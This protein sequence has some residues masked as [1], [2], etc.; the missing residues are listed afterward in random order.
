[1]AQA[2]PKKLSPQDRAEAVRRYRAMETAAVLH[3]AAQAHYNGLL[4]ELAAKH[5]IPKARA[6]VNLQTGE[7]SRNGRPA[8]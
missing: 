7:I 2:K 5:K 3:Q 6:V 1:M 8:S 4:T